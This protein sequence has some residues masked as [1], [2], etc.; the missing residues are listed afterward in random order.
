[1][2]TEQKQRK[3]AHSAHTQVS[4]SEPKSWQDVFDNDG[5]RVIT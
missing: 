1:M 3:V 2:E 5:H 4:A